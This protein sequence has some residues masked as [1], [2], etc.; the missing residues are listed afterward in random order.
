M[1]PL[2]GYATMAVKPCYR[3]KIATTNDNYSKLSRHS[4]AAPNA[5][6]LAGLH[7]SLE[8]R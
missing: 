5:F 3:P 8:W 2:P 4:F 6:Y 1:P 7:D